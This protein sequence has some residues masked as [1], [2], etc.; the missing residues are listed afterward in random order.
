MSFRYMGFIATVAFKR[1][2]VELTFTISGDF[3]LFE[4][5]SGWY[6]IASVVAVAVSLRFGLHPPQV[7]PMN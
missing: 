2:H 4:P 7:A 1:L 6:Q 3:D 5:I